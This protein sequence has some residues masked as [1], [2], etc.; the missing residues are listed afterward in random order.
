MS[1][2]THRVETF[3]VTNGPMASDASMGCNGA[4]IIPVRFKVHVNKSAAIEIADGPVAS[5]LSYKL[6]VIVTDHDGWEHCSVSLSSRTPTWEEMSFV[7]SLF[8]DPEDTLVNYRPAKSEYVNLHPNVLHWW[9][10]KDYE[11]PTPPSTLV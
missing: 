7:A 2:S 1:F 11:Y 8:W 6:T 3:R 5:K 10:P 9:R 4:F